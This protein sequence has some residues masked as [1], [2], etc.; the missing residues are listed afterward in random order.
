MSNTTLESIKMVTML[1]KAINGILGNIN[2]Q[3]HT[4][5][6]SKYYPEQ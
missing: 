2:P 4:K 3:E 6:D 1:S 5:G